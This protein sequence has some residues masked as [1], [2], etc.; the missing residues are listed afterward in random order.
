M[1]NWVECETLTDPPRIIII[2]L[3]RVISVSG[4]SLGSVVRYAET[5]DTGSGEIIVSCTPEKLL[6]GEKVRCA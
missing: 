3:E 5:N 2:N 6:S 1:P 4:N